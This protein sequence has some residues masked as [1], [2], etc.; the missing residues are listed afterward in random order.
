MTSKGITGNLIRTKDGTIEFEEA[1]RGILEVWRYPYYLTQGWDREHWSKRY[2]GG[3]DVSEGLG[4]SYSVGYI[5]DRERDEFV[6]RIRT[7]RT[8]AYTWAE[9]LHL[10]SDWYC[11]VR[12]WT[13]T[14]GLGREKAVLCVER[15]GAGQ[16][17]VK[18]LIELGANQYLRMIEGQQGGGHTKEFGWGETQQAKHDLS[19]DLRAWFRNMKGTLYDAILL[20][21]AS[22]WIKHEGSQRLGP[23]EGHLGDC[24]IA[25]G[26]TIQASKFL[27]G[28]PERI[29]HFD[30]GWMAKILEER[31]QQTGWTV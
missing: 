29:K 16:T 7:N 8:D 14:G 22:T 28:S 3:A 31:Q 13:R 15:T 30:T 5:L 21:E 18:R 23:E 11:N 9:Q 2:C 20:D 10:L 4:Q 27:G 26:C 17:T 19:E 12:Y 25:A 1:K 24:V 6:C